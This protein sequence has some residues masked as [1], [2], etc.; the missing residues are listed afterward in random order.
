MPMYIFYT[1]NFLRNGFLF[2]ASLLHISPY[3][4]LLTL[5]SFI[6]PLHSFPYR[7]H[8]TRAFPNSIIQTFQFP[9]SLKCPGLV[10]P[11]KRWVNA[12]YLFFDSFPEKKRVQ[13]RDC[14]VCGTK[15]NTAHMGVDVCRACTVFY[16]WICLHFCLQ[17]I[18]CIVSIRH[19]HIVC[20]TWRSASVV[21]S[22]RCHVESTWHK[23]HWTYRNGVVLTDFRRSNGKKK[24]FACR[25]GTSR[26][27]VGKGKLYYAFLLFFCF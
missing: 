8:V 23:Y 1:I 21:L 19:Y 5:T 18:D 9:N 24:P 25:S 16:R 15:T 14:L 22:L 13:Y 20:I 10:W 11:R 4:R 3:H 27:E 12:H 17:S 6:T 26:C 7:A 2:A